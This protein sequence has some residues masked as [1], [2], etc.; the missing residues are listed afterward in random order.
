MRVGRIVHHKIFAWGVVIFCLVTSISLVRNAWK[1]SHQPDHSQEE[2]KQLQELQSKVDK[3]QQ[4]I[5][6]QQQPFE[7]E[8]IIRDELNM[9]K[10]GEI[11]IQLPLLPTSTPRPEPTS[12]PT[13]KVYEQWWEVIRH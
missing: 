6:T 9:Q 3:L 10:E 2:N 5:N 4:D 7:Q 11:I 1:L 12:M 8:K 13:P